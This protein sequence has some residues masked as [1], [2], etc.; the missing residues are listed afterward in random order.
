MLKLAA[1]LATLIAGWSYPAAA[2]AASPDE[3]LIDCHDVDCFQREACNRRV[4]AALGASRTSASELR[5]Y[6]SPVLTT[7]QL[8]V[9]RA[10]QDRLRTFWAPECK[11][12]NLPSSE[13][14]STWGSAGGLFVRPSERS[15]HPANFPW[16]P[17]ALFRPIVVTTPEGRQRLLGRWEGWLSFHDDKSFPLWMHIVEVTPGGYVKACSDQGMIMGTVSEKG[18]LQLPRR[19]AFSLGSR[20]LLWRGPPHNDDLEG[21]VLLET[22]ANLEVDSG[23]VWLSRALSRAD[24]ILPTEY[25]CQDKEILDRR[26]ETWVP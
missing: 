4:L 19:E 6:L 7:K 8:D 23:L 1:V 25:V 17:P 12:T 3:D 26:K 9:L 16:S 11:P 22:A 5:G 21:V 15:S 13:S 2:S 24:A 10:R 18:V 14:S 20:I